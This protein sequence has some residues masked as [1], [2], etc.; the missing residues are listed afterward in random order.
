MATWR[1]AGGFD[2]WMGGLTH[3]PVRTRRSASTTRERKKLVAPFRRPGSIGAT[4]K[5]FQFNSC[6]EGLNDRSSIHRLAVEDTITTRVVLIVHVIG[7]SGR[8]T[9]VGAAALE[10]VAAAEDRS[11][12][13]SAVDH[14]LADDFVTDDVFVETAG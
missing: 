14:P 2:D 1:T 10:V 7:I 4:E 6:Y 5:R 11:V 9:A 3:G 13:D 12:G 8:L